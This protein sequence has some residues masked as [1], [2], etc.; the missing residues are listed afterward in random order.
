[1]KKLKYSKK[2]ISAKADDFIIES[3]KEVEKLDASGLHF[4]EKDGIE[5]FKIGTGQPKP[6]EYLGEGLPEVEK[7]NVLN[8]EV[9]ISFD[10]RI[11]S[12]G[13]GDIEFIIAQNGTG[14]HFKFK[15]KGLDPRQAQIAIIEFQSRL[16]SSTIL[17]DINHL[18]WASYRMNDDIKP[19]KE[20][21]HKILSNLDIRFKSIL[22]LNRYKK[23]ESKIVGEVEIKTFSSKTSGANQQSQEEL[24]TE[25]KIFLQDVFS[26]LKIIETEGGKKTQLDVGLI[27]FENNLDV[28][29][30]DITSRMKH[31]LRKYD[32]NFRNILSEYNQKKANN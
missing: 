9:N 19:R 17:K 29:N 22:N 4:F 15:Y 14:R 21:F 25:R 5:G 11:T 30:I 23:P 12:K 13:N 18:F 1:M 27:V 10:I 24:L 6:P 7:D 16:N 31:A 26:A 20:A 28:E 32:L 2:S 3:L 8:I